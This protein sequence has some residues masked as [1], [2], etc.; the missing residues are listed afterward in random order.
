MKKVMMV[1]VVAFVAMSFYGCGGSG[2]ETGTAAIKGKYTITDSET[3]EKYVAEVN[4]DSTGTLEQLDEND[5]VLESAS[6]SI[7]A[8]SGPNGVTFSLSAKFASGKFFEV[9]ICADASGVI[10]SIDISIDGMML[11]DY[12]VQEAKKQEV[13]AWDESSHLICDFNGCGIGEEPSY[14]EEPS[15]DEAPMP[16][17]P[18]P[19]DN[20]GATDPVPAESTPMI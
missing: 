6:L 3:G 7:S 20:N 14:D 19:G 5:Q 4:E 9:W 11:T 12:H 1:L 17:M 2:V 10:V 16:D 18:A 15:H 8:T 13:P